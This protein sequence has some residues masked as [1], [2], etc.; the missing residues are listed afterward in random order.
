[1]RRELLGLLACPVCRCEFDLR[2]SITEEGE[3]LEGRLICSG[4]NKEFPVADGI[5]KL[6]TD[7]EEKST[8][9]RFGYEWR[10]FPRISP[11]YERQFLDW[12]SP[13]DKDFFRGKIVLDAGCGKG[14]H[15]YLASRFEAKMI[16]GIDVS[17]AVGVA[18]ANTRDLPNVHLIQG[19]ICRPPLKRAF[20]YI[21]SI[22]VLH[23][24]SRPE[25][26]FKALRGLL[27]KGGTISIWVYG[28]EGNGWIVYF[29][30]PLRKFLT[31]KMPLSILKKASFPVAYFLYAL[32]RLLY[33]PVN[34]HLK[35][36]RR[37]LFYNDYLFYISHFDLKEV[38]SIVFDHLLAPVAF[39]IRRDE[40][41]AWFERSQFVDVKIAW[42]NKNSWKAMGKLG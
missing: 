34:L 13:I 28:K 22:G 40:V 36:F 1:M 26:G 19:D 4:C 31:S 2:E 27:K 6:L 15:L 11:A 33:R 39:Y 20:D 8:A 7:L 23:H 41:L 42:H 32:C 24:L 21:Y 17:E 29:V 14:R 5:P 25:E 18:R 3:V 12:I 9:E 30:N 16:V 38:H 10:S 37:F 35:S